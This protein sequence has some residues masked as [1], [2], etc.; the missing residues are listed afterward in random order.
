MVAC[1]SRLCRASVSRARDCAGA[2][3]L[4]LGLGER[5][6]SRL[7]LR[8]ADRVEPQ[9]IVHLAKVLVSRAADAAQVD[10]DRSAGRERML[11]EHIARRQMPA[12]V[13]W[14]AHAAH[15]RLRYRVPDPSPLVSVIVPTRDRAELLA[16]CVRSLSRSLYPS[17]E[18][19][20]VDNGSIEE[21]THLLAQLRDERAIRILPI[22]VRSTIQPSTMRQLARPARSS[23]FST[24]ISKS[25]MT[26]G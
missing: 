13:V 16:T 8:L 6:R 3:G 17:L 15:P 18:V 2:R 22:P 14:P 11:R 21:A 10:P 20:I 7:K 9:T 25:S 1:K 23:R 24:T 19:I 4:A 26:I 12:D 5:D